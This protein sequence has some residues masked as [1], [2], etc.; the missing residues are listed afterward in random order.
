MLGHSCLQIKNFRPIIRKQE[1]QPNA[2]TASCSPA[3]CLHTTVD[4]ASNQATL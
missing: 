1:A 4:S 2:K 3:L